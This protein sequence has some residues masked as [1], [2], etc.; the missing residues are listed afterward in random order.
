LVGLQEVAE[1]GVQNVDE[2]GDDLTMNVVFY[3][4]YYL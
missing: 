1:L 2:M 3:W 4:G